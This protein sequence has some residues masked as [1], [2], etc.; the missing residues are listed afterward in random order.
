MSSSRLWRDRDLRPTRAPLG[1]E[2]ASDAELDSLGLV[3]L[4]PYLTGA[5]R[6]CRTPTASRACTTCS[7]RSGS[8]HLCVVDD[9]N[10]VVGMVTRKELLD[11]WLEERLDHLGTTPR[12]SG[13]SRGAR[14]RA[15]QRRARALTRV[16]E[17]RTRRGEGFH[18]LS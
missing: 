10:R 15:D 8:R 4:R 2:T 18:R 12:G 9:C 11:D 13:K 5:R 6:A 7:G 17:Y 14:V 3:D 16:R 1:R